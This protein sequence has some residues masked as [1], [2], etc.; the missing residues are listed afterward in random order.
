MKDKLAHDAACKKIMKSRFKSLDYF[1]QAVTF[2]YD[3]DD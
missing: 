3:G 2:T 1:G